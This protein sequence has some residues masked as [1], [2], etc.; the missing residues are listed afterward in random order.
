MYTS[1]AQ[2]LAAGFEVI[3]S[4]A[5]GCCIF[6]LL[7]FHCSLIAQGLTTKQYIKTMER[8]MRSSSISHADHSREAILLDGPPKP[9]PETLH[10]STSGQDSY[11]TTS[12][13]SS[14]PNSPTRLAP[15]SSFP[16]SGALPTQSLP[17]APSFNTSNTFP[18]QPQSPEKEE[19][20]DHGNQGDVVIHIQSKQVP[21]PKDEVIDEKRT[22]S[23]GNTL[24]TNNST[25]ESSVGRSSSGRASA[26]EN[27]R[28]S[29]LVIPQEDTLVINTENTTIGCVQFWQNFISLY[30]S[31]LPP[32]KIAKIKYYHI[33]PKHRIFY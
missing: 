17:P 23:H 14:T 33:K 8:P 25:M 26:S 12:P 20:K 29:L 3:M 30:K 13:S 32:S 11:A 28:S 31:P 9:L 6:G 4:I 18:L 15:T 5:V 16:S 21:D 1:I 19:D 10:G 7:G 2:N 24:N 27:L 22:E